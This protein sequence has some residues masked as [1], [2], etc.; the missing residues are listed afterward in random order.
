MKITKTILLFTAVVLLGSCATAHKIS[1][2]KMGMNKDEV[3]A[4]MGTPTSVSAQGRTEYL[5][6]ALSET[7]D[8][9]FY[10]ITTP[11]YVRFI[12]G[13]V[14]SFGRSGDFD[15]TK[16]PAIRVENDQKVKQDIRVRDSGDLYTELNK[17]KEL[18]DSGIIT[19]KEFELQ[20]KKL[21]EKY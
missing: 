2:L 18:K 10:G 15:S 4:V 13:K 11:Y 8:H 20:K 9:A 7:D 17:L 3:I 12:D 5:N 6:Y 19:E 16:T 21:L 14:E 1:G